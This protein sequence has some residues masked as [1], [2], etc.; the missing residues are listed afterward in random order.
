ME[1][2]CEF[3]GKLENWVKGKIDIKLGDNICRTCIDKMLLM[4]LTMLTLHIKAL[5]EFQKK[6][7][8]KHSGWMDKM[9]G[10]MNKV[11]KEMNEGE[12]WKK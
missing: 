4:E 12:D 1:E 5:L 9:F 11:D 2:K 6:L 10:W 7:T 8:S 3:C